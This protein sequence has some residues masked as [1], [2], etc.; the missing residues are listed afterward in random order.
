MF[1]APPFLVPA[2]SLLLALPA[3]AA[4]CPADGFQAL[5]YD[6]RLEVVPAER[7]VA[8]DVAVELERCGPGDVVALDARD[9][10]VAAVSAGGAPLPFTHDGTTLRIPLPRSA[11][12][13]EVRVRYT[14]RPTR[15]MRFGPDYV[16]TVF[17]TGHWMVTRA[18][19][20]DKAELALSVVLPAGF[21]AV[22]GGEE[23]GR[24]ALPDGRVRFA[25]RLARPHSSYLFGFAAGRFTRGGA[26]GGATRLRYAAQGFTPAQLDTVFAATAPALRFFEE[27][28]GV[29][30]PGASYVQ[31]LVPG[32][33]G[34]EMAQMAVMDTAYGRSVLADP[35][36]DYLVVHEL[37]HAWWG[38]LLTNADWGDFWL[39]EG[40]TTFMVAA[41]KERRWG[42]DEYEREML[43]ARAGYERALAASPR[44]VAQAGLRTSDEAG[45]PVTYSGGARV[46]HFLRRQMGER[47]FWNGMRAYTRAGAAT[48]VVR[49]ADLRRAMERASG[50][51][52]AWL[53][54]A[55]V[56]GA[57]PAPLRARHT[58]VPGAVVLVLEHPAPGGMLVDVAVETGSGR[59]ART[60]MMTAPRQ[61]VRIPVAGSV[62][63]VRVD[64]GG[65]LPLRPD[66]ERP[67]A[68]L[69]HQLA[70]EPDP[71]GRA[72]ALLELV[73]VCPA[74]SAC[75]GAR[76]A[77]QHAAASDA[78]R[79]VR[80]L[81]ARSVQAVAP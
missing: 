14:A 17:H 37:A 9:M 69:L 77:V 51:D 30:Y 7:T 80:Q 58:V 47:A 24:E 65:F 21:D 6:A 8:G 68:M 33:R 64:A 72:D 13:Q 19:P 59:V 10:V 31:A 78:S 32:A 49:T 66:H 36:E 23:L 44:P 43:I 60:V 62:R 67:V 71:A 2:L 40:V 20:A 45:G 55:W 28:S 79:Y 38:N 57:P 5:R 75:P 4:P 41:Y 53:F 63:S 81:A 25:W 12:R 16:H 73:R 3:R 70:H 35:R 76:A 52:L 50:R 54:D 42:R 22:S 61:E 46:L 29:R 26:R 39:N 18:D 48:G 27:V 74:G 11:R 1:Q 15:G 34:Q 56:H